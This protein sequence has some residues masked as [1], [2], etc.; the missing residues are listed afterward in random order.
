MSHEDQDQML[1]VTRLQMHCFAV[2]RRSMPRANRTRHTQLRPGKSRKWQ[3]RHRSRLP[4][5]T[6]RLLPLL[7]ILPLLP[8]LALLLS[9]FSLLTHESLQPLIKT[10]PVRSLVRDE[11]VKRRQDPQK[12][13]YRSQLLD[14]RLEERLPWWLAE[15]F[16]VE[17][18]V[19]LDIL[20]GED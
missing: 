8:L 1:C 5:K 18:D 20:E 3:H 15:T 4:R 10:R 19:F 9:L 2:S 16:D 14:I 13:I 7:T 17:G 6:R 11:W 12:L